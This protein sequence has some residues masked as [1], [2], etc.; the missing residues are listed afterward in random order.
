MVPLEY[1]YSH[2]RS[3]RRQR[4]ARLSQHRKGYTLQLPNGSR[5]TVASLG[6]LESTRYRLLRL[7]RIREWRSCAYFFEAR[8]TILVLQGSVICKLGRIRYAAIFFHVTPWAHFTIMH[9]SERGIVQLLSQSF[10]TW[11]TYSF[12]SPVFSSYTNIIQILAIRIPRLVRRIS[13]NI[14]IAL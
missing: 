5:P 14:R 6:P 3:D 10:C 9:R 12:L 7:G 2:S 11:T 8:E 4:Q 1:N 13:F